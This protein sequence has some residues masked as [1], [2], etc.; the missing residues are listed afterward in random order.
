MENKLNHIVFLIPGFAQNEQDSTTIPA[1]QLY[2]KALKNQHPEFQITI[3]TFH[4]PYT[5]EKYNWHNCEVIPLNGCN[6]KW[7][8][9]YVWYKAYKV[10][11]EINKKNPISIV[12]SFWLNECTFIGNIFSKNKNIKHICTSIGQDVLKEKFYFKIF[13][14]KKTV[15]ICESTIQKKIFLTKNKYNPKVVSWGIDTNDF[16]FNANKTIDIIGVGSLIPIKNFQLFIDII[17]EV[18]KITPVKTMIIGEGFEKE[19]IQKKIKEL[20][21]ENVITLTGL[22]NY[23]GTLS[24]ISKSKILLH[25]SN[26]EGFGMIFAEA[27]QCKTMVVSKE[28]G[29]AYSSENWHICT[30]KEEMI[31][32]CVKALSA[33]FLET[34]HHPFLIEKQLTII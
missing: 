27:L 26:H 19:M 23:R 16:I 20:K 34:E 17:Y 32:A 29:C 11:S 33:T 18:N 9:A 6:I 1:I 13:P 12:H 3:I 8:Q 5:N 25:T 21:L 28:V 4:F 30:S 10:L 14:L 24:N 31:A 2:I 15:L 22:L 7:K